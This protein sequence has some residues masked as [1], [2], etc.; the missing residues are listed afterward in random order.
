MNVNYPDWEINKLLPKKNAYS[1]NPLK[2]CYCEYKAYSPKFTSKSN[3]EKSLVIKSEIVLDPNWT[4][5]TKVT[6]LQDAYTWE[7]I[8]LY[9]A[10]KRKDISVLHN[11][12]LPKSEAYYDANN[13]KISAASYEECRYKIILNLLQTI[14]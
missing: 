6:E 5:Y 10:S 14:K 4:R 13:D 9:L 2:W 3:T 11:S 7:E 12:F 1:K 8:R